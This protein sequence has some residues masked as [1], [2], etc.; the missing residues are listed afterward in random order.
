MVFVGVWGV[1]AVVTG[2]GFDELLVEELGEA[3]KSKFNLSGGASG[4]GVVVVIV[5]VVVDLRVDPF[6]FLSLTP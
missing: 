4:G 6:F 3:S 5:G 2:L 1:A